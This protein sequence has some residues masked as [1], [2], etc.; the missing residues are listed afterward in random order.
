MQPAAAASEQLLFLKGSLWVIPCA[1]ARK[2]LKLARKESRTKA[3]NLLRDFPLIHT[4]HC[5]LFPLPAFPSHLF[6]ETLLIAYE[7]A[8][9]TLAWNSLYNSSVS[10]ALRS[11]K[12]CMYIHKILLKVYL[13]FHYRTAKYYHSFTSIC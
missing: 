7:R 11:V 4:F 6:I 1:I 12:L 2:Q 8:K 13:K 5:A 9:K 10:P 3:V